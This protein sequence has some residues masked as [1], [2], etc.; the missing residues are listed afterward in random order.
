VDK[1]RKISIATGIALLALSIERAIRLTTTNDSSMA[2]LFDV[3]QMWCLAWIG[4][5]TMKPWEAR[6]GWE[7]MLRRSPFLSATIFGLVIAVVIA[8][9]TAVIHRWG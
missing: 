1:E 2:D 3:V 6:A 9:I 5:A 7:R 4:L 8:L